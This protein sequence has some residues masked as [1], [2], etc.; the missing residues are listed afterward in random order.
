M[1]SVADSLAPAFVLHRRPYSETS[2]ILEVFTAEHG[3]VG[4]LAKG[5]RRRNNKGAGAL[6]PFQTLLVSWRGRGELPTLTRVEPD[7]HAQSLS[8][9]NLVS[10]FYINELLMRLL[11]R[12]DPHPE[13]WNPYQ[14]TVARLTVDNNPEP[15]L[16][17]F[18][19]HLLAA[20]GYGLELTVDSQGHPIATGQSYLYDPERGAR[21][22]DG[23]DAISGA[24]LL[25]LEHETLDTTTLPEA[26]RLMRRLLHRRL[27]GKPL[28][29]RT[30][31]RQ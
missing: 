13:L 27:D 30:L 3:R 4:L 5:A 14:Q 17:Y 6:Q 18:E 16:R 2:L 22:D 11:E 19:K 8:G 12:H 20:I 9:N 26:K 24:T 31:L 15:A 29:S 25:A 1:R 23:P 21:A 7:G 10:G 28:V